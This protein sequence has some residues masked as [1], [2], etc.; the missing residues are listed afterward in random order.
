MA[1]YQQISENDYGWL[2]ENLHQP[3]NIAEYMWQ[4]IR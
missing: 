1:S 4:R 3:E 2:E